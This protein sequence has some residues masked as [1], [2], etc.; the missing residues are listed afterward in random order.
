MFFFR[1][2]P[3]IAWSGPGN[4]L[5]SGRHGYSSYGRHLTIL[6][7]SKSDE[8]DYVCNA[9]NSRGTTQ[10]TL[11]IRVRVGGTSESEFASHL[12]PYLRQSRRIRLNCNCNFDNLYYSIAVSLCQ[13]MSSNP[14]RWMWHSQKSFTI[15]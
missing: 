10:R 11:N 3:R 8:G 14:Y 13:V 4:D 1:P 6:N 7:I 15:A 5:P 12:I 2:L 9:T